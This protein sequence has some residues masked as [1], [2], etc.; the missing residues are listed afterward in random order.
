M[1]GRPAHT[2][3][4]DPGAVGEAERCTGTVPGAGLI[5]ISSR[6]TGLEDRHMNP[7]AQLRTRAASPVTNASSASSKLSWSSSRATD[8]S[9]W[10]LSRF[11]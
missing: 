1:L 2:D 8:G 3:H 5:E 7:K 10:A 6:D 9:R 11:G 4:D